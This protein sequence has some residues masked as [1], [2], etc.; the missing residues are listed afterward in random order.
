MC[1]YVCVWGVCIC[2]Y[3]CVVCVCVCVLFVY[4]CVCSVCV[5]V[6]GFFKLLLHSMPHYTVILHALHNLRF[7]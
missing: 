1:V 4:V 2:K 5:C 7:N 3:V 6:G